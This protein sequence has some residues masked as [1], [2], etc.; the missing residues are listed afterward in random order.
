MTA[1]L[2]KAVI[3]IFA[4]VLRD[5]CNSASRMGFINFVIADTYQI[6]T[7]YDQYS[8]EKK[9]VEKSNFIRKK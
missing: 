9:M 2:K 7:Y 4:M 8:S 6:F 1:F 3:I 5:P